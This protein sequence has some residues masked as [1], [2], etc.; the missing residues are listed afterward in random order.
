MGCLN[1]VSPRV[2]EVLMIVFTIIGIGFLVWGIVDIPWDDITNAGKAFFYI[3][4]AFMVLILLII[5]ILM[6]LRIGNK[7]NKS[8]NGIGKCLT[9]TLMVFNIMALIVF[10]IAE[11]IIFINMGDKN[12]EYYEN[13]YQI[14]RRRWRNK[15]SNSEWFST[16]CSLTAAEIALALNIIVLNYLIKVIWA[17]YSTCY[18]D[19]LEYNKKENI[20]EINALNT[21]NNLKSINIYN[22]PPVNNQN[23]LTFIGYDQN[24]HPI[25]SGSNQYFTKNVPTNV[26]SNKNLVKE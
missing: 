10:I 5:L 2:L 13:N 3:G 9:V 4:C 22:T 19:Y 14:N 24:G 7:I 12:D 17:K 11:I 8:K 25:Y 21:G 16:I 15:Y 6:C 1:S 18:N 26:N 20:T 23:I